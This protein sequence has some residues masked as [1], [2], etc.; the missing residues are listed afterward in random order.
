M[1]VNLKQTFVQYFII[2]L[3]TMMEPIY[4]RFIIMYSSNRYYVVRGLFYYGGYFKCGDRLDIVKTTW[5][6]T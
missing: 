5:E 1:N 6:N 3:Y 2:I 4:T